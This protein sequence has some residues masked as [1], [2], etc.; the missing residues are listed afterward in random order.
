[1]LLRTNGVV[2]L[3]VEGIGCKVDRMPLGIADHHLRWVVPPVRQAPH[4][5]ARLRSLSE[6]WI[7][8]YLRWITDSSIMLLLPAGARPTIYFMGGY[9]F[10]ST[11]PYG[12][13][14]ID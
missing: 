10:D 4:P 14:V 6:P 13:W 7:A 9:P 8:M 5:Q 3:A 11:N 12:L 2:P 1:M